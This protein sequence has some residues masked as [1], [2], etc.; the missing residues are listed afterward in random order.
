M[1]FHFYTEAHSKVQQPNTISKLFWS[2]DIESLLHL[3]GK[4]NDRK[5]LGIDMNW[6]HSKGNRKGRPGGGGGGGGAEQTSSKHPFQSV[7]SSKAKL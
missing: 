1:V 3:F 4:K 6:L 7:E 5:A 2:T